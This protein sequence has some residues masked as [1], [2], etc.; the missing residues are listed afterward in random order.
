MAYQRV[1][2]LTG[3]ERRRN[4]TSAQKA[5][6]VE[7]AFRPGVVV[8]EAARRFG[9]HES[10]LYRWRR[11]MMAAET[12]EFVAVTIAAE[13]EDAG[14]PT[15]ASVTMAL[16]TAPSPVPVAGPRAAVEI[17]L[18]G[19]A[20]VRL[21]GAVDPALATAVLAALAPLRRVP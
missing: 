12:T 4:Y 1:E 7:E 3:N 18:P 2:I 17:V 10:L 21:D 19:G 11:L 14:L 8:T 13:P 15:P 6:M 5:R 9:V 16:P 20:R